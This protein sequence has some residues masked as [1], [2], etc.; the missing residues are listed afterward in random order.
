LALV[1]LL[2]CVIPT[3]AKA[4]ELIERFRTDGLSRLR[5]LEAIYYQ[6]EGL[7]TIDSSINPVDKA[8]SYE[9]LYQGGSRRCIRRFDLKLLEDPADKSRF[10]NFPCEIVYGANSEY[11]FRLTRQS[12]ADPYVVTYFGKERQGLFSNPDL[13]LQRSFL[14]PVFL[15]G[16]SLC[17]WQEATN[18]SIKGANSVNSEGK[19]L[20]RLQ[21]ACVK[22]N[23]ADNELYPGFTGEVL[24]DPER[25]WCITKVHLI[26]HRKAFGKED[27]PTAISV[28]FGPS[29]DGKPIPQKVIHTTKFSGIP[30][31]VETF[32]LSNVRKRKA[33]ESEFT[34]SS[35]NVS[36]ISNAPAAAARS[37]LWIW[38]I[39]LGILAALAAF[40]VRRRLARS[41]A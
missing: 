8:H 7:L 41:G 13:H 20:V 21:V 39:G 6:L 4:D 33:S 17:A 1:L 35:F 14:A 18:F 38:L 10:A 15:C 16:K 28:D 5:E 25:F 24:L 23:P 3:N 12:S 2:S 22:E 32:T 26:Y 37:Y 40:F 30:D 36:E 9:F 29:I 19:T 11:G 34:L 31:V 27:G